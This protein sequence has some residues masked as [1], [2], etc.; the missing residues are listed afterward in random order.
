MGRSKQRPYKGARSKRACKYAHV[1]RGK[2]NTRDLGPRHGNRW[3][4]KLNVA[5]E[6]CTARCRLWM[7]IASVAISQ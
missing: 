2:F 5:S 1:S 6:P 7:K 3:A 4:Q